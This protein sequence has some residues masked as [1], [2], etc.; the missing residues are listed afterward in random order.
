MHGI[1]TVKVYTVDGELPLHGI[2]AH[3]LPCE[4]FSI[5]VNIV[6]VILKV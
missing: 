2:G 6:K 1:Q 4:A 3:F 5:V